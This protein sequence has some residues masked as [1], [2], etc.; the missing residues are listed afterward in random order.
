MHGKGIILTFAKERIL[1][2][3]KSNGSCLQIFI[4]GRCHPECVDF[5]DANWLSAEIRIDVPGFHGCYGTH[6]RSDDFSRFRDELEEVERRSR[7]EATFSTME[8]GLTLQGVLKC[9]GQLV[10]KGIARHSSGDSTLTFEM[11][12]DY[13]SLNGLI[14]DITTLLKEYPV[15]S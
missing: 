10:W 14:H 4:Q 12:T 6:L 5:E 1:M 13:A 7:T 9:T 11:E 8:E 2:E 15:I 3:I